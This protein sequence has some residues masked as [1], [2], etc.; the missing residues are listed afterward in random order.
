MRPKFRSNVPL[1]ATTLLLL[2]LYMSAVLYASRRRNGDL[3]DA[4]HRLTD[5]GGVRVLPRAQLALTALNA[6]RVLDAGRPWKAWRLLRDLVD[7]PTAAPGEILLAARSAS[8]WEGWYNVEHLLKGRPWLAEENAGEGLLLLARAQ[9]ERDEREDA[10][11][12]YRRYLAVPAAEERGVAAAH[13]GELLARAGD[14]AGAAAAFETAGSAVPAVA[15]WLAALRTEQLAAAHDPTAVA[16][17]VRAPTGSA[18]ARVRRVEAEAEARRAAGDTD[19]ALRRLE[20]EARILRG[21]G[22]RAEAAQL[23]YDRAR[24]LHAADR[25]GDAREALRQAAWESSA[26]P[27]LRRR[28]AEMLESLDPRTVAEEL[29]CSAAYEAARRPGLAARALRGAISLGAPAD[30]GLQLKLARLLYDARDFGPARDAFQAA[31]SQLNDEN[32][33]AEAELGAARSLYRSGDR[34]HDAAIREYKEVVAGH[35]GTAAA[36]SALF[37]LGD[38]SSTTERGLGYYRRAAEVRSSPDAADALYRVGDRYLKLGNPAAAARAWAEYAARYPVGDRTAQVAYEAAKL[39]ARLGRDDAAR[40]LYRA[41]L[42]AEPASYYGVRA[43]E[44]LDESPLAGAV[45]EPWIGLAGDAADAASALQRLAALDSLGLGDAWSAE[46]DGATRRFSD[47]PAALLALGEGVR[48]AGH[49]VEGIRIGRTLLARR[50]GRWDVRLLRLVFPFPYQDIVKDDA[51]R[52]GVDPMLLAGLVRQESSFDPYARSWVG[53]RGLAQFMPATAR[54]LADDAGIENFDGSLLDVPEISLRM[55]AKYLSDL[56]HRYDGAADLA[57]A[58]YNAGPSRAD[59]W[60]RTLGH[61]GDPDR[62]REA[63]PFDE[64]RQYVMIVLRNAALYR[65]LYGDG[66]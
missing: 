65:A 66:A 33:V 60:R 40:D 37:L 52:E 49:P 31:A 8:Q 29:A 42:A 45:A 54:W 22:A 38:V 32:L 41:A 26:D 4:M 30:A 15:D 23:D 55:G 11:A 20:W 39:E 44:H 53:A 1:I 9:E 48:D 46:L 57:L 63:I 58:A 62:F 56:L 16:V 13:L 50:G 59:R 34:H 3:I 51:K 12:T 14:H 2:V 6:Q 28:A 47:R 7:E 35:P 5:V 27:S 10:V 43:A 19:G 24:V 64:T 61:G 21:D 36:G 17:S 25:N 18:P